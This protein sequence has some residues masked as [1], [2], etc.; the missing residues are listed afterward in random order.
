MCDFM[1]IYHIVQNFKY[2]LAYDMNKDR[3]VQYIIHDLVEMTWLKDNFKAKQMTLI[4]M[5]NEPTS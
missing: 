1:I 4:Q 3:T 5:Q 2:S